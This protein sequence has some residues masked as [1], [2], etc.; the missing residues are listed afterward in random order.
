MQGAA[1]TGAASTQGSSKMWRSST[2]SS[3]YAKQVLESHKKAL[4]TGIRP[5]LPKEGD[6]RPP[7]GNTLATGAG[8]PFI[9]GIGAPQNSTGISAANNL[10]NAMNV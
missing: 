1:A 8:N 10:K 9:N 6:D 3:N 4:A 7:Q 5:T 2:Q